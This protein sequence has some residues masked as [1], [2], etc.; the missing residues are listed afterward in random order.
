MSEPSARPQ[1]RHELTT[2]G[3]REL[4]FDGLEILLDVPTEPSHPF[5]GEGAG[6]H[7]LACLLALDLDQVDALELLDGGGDTLSTETQSPGEF[8]GV[9]IGLLEKELEGSEL[10]VRDPTGAEGSVDGDL[11]AVLNPAGLD[12]DAPAVGHEG[13][14]THPRYF[15]SRGSDTREQAFM[16]R[17]PLPSGT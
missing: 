11:E 4:P 8:R 1:E 10:C 13:A 16:L 3:R 5:S 9:Q 17:S 2:A 6:G 15:I 14:V 12:H 7:V